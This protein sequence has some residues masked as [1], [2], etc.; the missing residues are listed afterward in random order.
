MHDRSRHVVMNPAWVVGTC[1]VHTGT[2]NGNTVELNLVKKNTL[3][4]NFCL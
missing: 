4:T 1:S 3:K 2:E